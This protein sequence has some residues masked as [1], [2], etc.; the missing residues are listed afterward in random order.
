MLASSHKSSQNK[1]NNENMITVIVVTILGILLAVFFL[2][3]GKFGGDGSIAN[4]TTDNTLT[5]PVISQSPQEASTTPPQQEQ[6]KSLYKT[7]PRAPEMT[8][9]A[10]T[11]YK[12][13]IRTSMGDIKVDLFEDKVPVTVNSFVF[14]AMERFYDNIKFHRVIKD[15]M[16][17]TGDPLGNGTGGPGYT[18]NDEPFTGEYEAGTLAMANSGPNTNGS[19]FF[20]MHKPVAL[21]KLYTIF[22][23]VSDEES[24][25][26]VDKISNV[27]VKPNE[28]NENASPIDPITIL[29]I[30]VIY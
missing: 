23:K 5:S 12:A 9:K 7:Y 6:A 25:K 8:L 18:F 3:Q 16:I 19:Q 11:D 22:G 10:K 20:I 4:N 2:K 29:G 27:S 30:E 13:V 26:V 1:D 24:M 15:F 17:Q 21:Q 28:N 14:L